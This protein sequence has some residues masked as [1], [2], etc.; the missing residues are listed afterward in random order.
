M[1]AVHSMSGSSLIMYTNENTLL[2]YG[3]VMTYDKVTHNRLSE[4]EWREC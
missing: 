2:G 4:K 1:S 3:W